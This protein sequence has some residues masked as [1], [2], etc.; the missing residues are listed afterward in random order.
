MRSSASKILS[1]GRSVCVRFLRD[2]GAQDLIEYALLTGVIASGTIALL[3]T[4]T[5]T[6]SGAYVAWQTGRNALAT[7]SPPAP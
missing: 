6:L 7:P 5:S 4:M 2:D 3:P 1:S